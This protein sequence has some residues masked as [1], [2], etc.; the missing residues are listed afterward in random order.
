MFTF[1]KEKRYSLI[2]LVVITTGLLVSSPINA[3]NV[4]SGQLIQ[5]LKPQALLDSGSLV[6]NNF[7]NDGAIGG[8]LRRNILDDPMLSGGNGL[9]HRYTVHSPDF[10]AGYPNR[11]AGINTFP[12]Q[13]SFNSNQFSF[14]L[15]DFIRSATKGRIGLGGVMRFS[16]PN[17][18]DGTA[19]QFVLGD[20]TME[21]DEK[22]K[23]N[24]QFLNKPITPSQHGVSGW[25][26]RNHFD[27][28]AVSYDMLNTSIM[29][30]S[31]SFYIS[32]QLGWSPEMTDSFLTES[33]LY[34][35][36]SD[37]VMCGQDDNAQN[38]NAAKQIPCV[39]PSVK[40]N[41]Q[42]G[43]V[44]VNSAGNIN[45]SV[46]LGV[47]TANSVDN[48]DYFVVFDYNGTFYW[49]NTSFQWT[50]TPTAAY[51]GAL[52]DFRSIPLPS[53]SLPTGS[54]PS[55]AN[56]TIYFGVDAT[57][58]GVLDQPQRYT[59]VNVKIR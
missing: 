8:L 28:P 59:T 24:Y 33:A 54:L 44:N 29:T 36:V 14:D 7:F 45:L 12:S 53:P 4:T 11:V 42:T 5:T 22:R 19:R 35:V 56:V 3:L 16:L 23:D 50:T 30:N 21:F 47:A 10:K 41:N 55:G 25:L 51:Q 57:R 52:F 43:T 37:F 38:A 9:V 48:A 40:V 34:N 49:M 31:D 20:F 18:A 17:L 32:G 58:N 46:D 15:N 1:L 2:S 13:F 27:F 26:L 6:V 39:F